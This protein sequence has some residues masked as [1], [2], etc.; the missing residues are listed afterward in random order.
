MRELRDDGEADRGLRLEIRFVELGG[1]R[2]RRPVRE[3]APDGRVATGAVEAIPFVEVHPDA[4]HH[5]AGAAREPA[6]RGPDD[7]VEVVRSGP[8]VRGPVDLP[9]QVAHRRSR[10]FRGVSAAEPLLGPAEV[11]EAAGVLEQHPGGVG[12]REG[13]VAGDL[14]QQVPVGE[15]RPQLIDAEGG[16]RGQPSRA[17]SARPRHQAGTETERDREAR[18]RLRQLWFGVRQGG[19]PLGEPGR[20]VGQDPQQTGERETVDILVEVERE[21]QAVRLRI[22]VDPCLMHA[23]ERYGLLAV[24]GCGGGRGCLRSTVEDEVRAHRGDRAGPGDSPSEEELPP[25]RPCATGV[26]ALNGRGHQWPAPLWPSS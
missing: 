20:V 17:G 18:R 12:H 22:R 24:H 7:L 16:Q 19:I 23:E 14:Q 3:G 9:E 11:R 26:R 8:G 6:V 2:E 21:E 25:G 1:A 5:H 13:I 10:A 4:A 15:L